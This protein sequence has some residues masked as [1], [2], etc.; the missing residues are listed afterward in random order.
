MQ[1]ILIVFLF[2]SFLFQVQKVQ[3]NEMEAKP[4]AAQDATSAK[5][6]E[7]MSEREPLRIKQKL[8]SEEVSGVVIGL[9]RKQGTEVLLK[10]VK[11]PV[12]IPFLSYHNK[13]F[14]RCLESQKNGKPVTL[15]IE[16]RSRQV[17][18][19]SSESEKK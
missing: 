7:G 19:D 3:A 6:Q 2:V 11:D 5:E 13:I 9:R 16:P 15:R 8:A 14:N 12:V 10:G 17:L 4:A 1:S 18:D